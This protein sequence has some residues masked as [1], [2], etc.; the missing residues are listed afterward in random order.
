MLILD[1]FQTYFI[2]DGK[3]FLFQSSFYFLAG[4]LTFLPSTDP[5]Q[6]HFLN[7]QLG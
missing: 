3:L 6:H 5:N 1:N 2:I 7:R 4:Y